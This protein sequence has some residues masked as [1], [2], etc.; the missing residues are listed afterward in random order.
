[1]S[2]TFRTV[3]KDELV[4]LHV[5]IAQPA[6]P[7]FT[8]QNLNTGDDYGKYLDTATGAWSDQPVANSMVPVNPASGVSS[9]FKSVQGIDPSFL[10]FV[11]G[12]SVFVVINHGIAGDPGSNESFVITFGSELHNQVSRLEA[13]LLPKRMEISRPNSL[14]VQRSVFDARS[15]GS[16]VL[17]LTST[18]NP[19]G[20]V[21][22]T[23]TNDT[24]NINSTGA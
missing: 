23:V 3:A 19:G 6:A 9:V 24:A 21:E 20:L 7:T 11:S 18:Q 1:M 15:G 2:T 10:G 22:E 16:E 4:T 8:V 14:T 13:L 12:D 17:R 5:F